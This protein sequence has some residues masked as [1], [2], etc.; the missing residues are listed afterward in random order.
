MAA[1]TAS[2]SATTSVPDQAVA[3]GT[4]RS[5]WIQTNFETFRD[6]IDSHNDRRERLIKT[7]RDITALSKK[8]IFLLHRFPIP[9]FSSSSQFKI[10]QR[11]LS[12]AHAKISEIACLI[13]RA[14]IE[15]NLSA[16]AAVDGQEDPKT[17][18]YR[19]ERNIG[20]GLE[21]FIEGVSFFHFLTT[22]R[23]ISPDEVQ[24]FLSVKDDKTGE[25]RKIMSLKDP[26]VALEVPDEFV[27]CV[28]AREREREREGS[29]GRF[30]A[31][32]PDA[33]PQTFPIPTSRYLLGISDLTGELMRFATNSLSSTNNTNAD[34]T[35]VVK[36]VLNLL[37][38][39]YE[40]ERRRTCRYLKHTTSSLTHYYTLHVLCSA[41]TTHTTSPRPRQEATHHGTVVA[42]VRGSHVPVEHSHGRICSQERWWQWSRHGPKCGEGDDEEGIAGWQR[43]WACRRGC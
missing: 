2:A 31:D 5:T 15:E 4:S 19:Y 14:G 22:R 6:E 9:D 40:G 21:E 34:P 23:L 1:A 11:L 12:D 20:G 33:F 24:A 28:S 43:R 30:H 41:H 37:R 29:R 16:A 3:S 17:N 26:S 35:A 32:R 10:P 38:D 27:S 39:L 18:R 25:K 8:L 13:L 7:S 36:L 42:K